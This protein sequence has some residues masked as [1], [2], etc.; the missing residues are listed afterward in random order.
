VDI[1]RKLDKGKTLRK[2]R[3]YARF[4]EKEHAS[5]YRLRENHTYTGGRKPTRGLTKCT[6]KQK[7]LERSPT[8]EKLLAANRR[9]VHDVPRARQLFDDTFSKER[10]E[11]KG[12]DRMA[13]LPTTEMCGREADNASKKRNEPTRGPQ[14]R[15]RRIK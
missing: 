10:K 5:P 15:Q 6:V 13:S 14:R 4:I 12:K 11:S 8:G 2:G 9:T 3:K 1:R 7:D